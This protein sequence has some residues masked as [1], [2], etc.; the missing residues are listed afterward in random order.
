[1]EA[2]QHIWGGRYNP[3]VPVTDGKIPDEWQTMIRHY[4]PDYV[5]YPRDLN[6]DAIK[7]LSFLHPKEFID[8]PSDILKDWFA[9]VNIHCLM[10]HAMGR[11]L[12]VDKLCVLKNEMNWKTPV[13]A[14]SFYQMNLG[15][16]D[17]YMGED[18][19][20]NDIPQVSVTDKTAHLI[21]QIIT[22][23]APFFKNILSAT[24][25]TTCLLDTGSSYQMEQFEWIVYNEE[26]YLNDLLY[27]WNRQQYLKPDDRIQQIIS[28]TGEL[29]LLIKDSYFF[30]TLGH[31]AYTS[32]FSLVS[33]S[34]PEAELKELSDAIKVKNPRFDLR[35]L[36]VNEFPFT[37]FRLN[38]ISAKYFSPVNNLI[39][40]S[41][42]FLKF[43]P[44]SF[45]SGRP[46]N[47][48]VYA[49]DTIIQRT[50]EESN[51]IKFPFETPLHHLL[52]ESKCRVN[53]QRRVTLFANDKMMGT[54]IKISSDFEIV[55]GLLNAREKYGEYISL[56]VQYVS[57][58]N[59]GQKLSALFKLLDE[60]WDNLQSFLEER[61]WVD[62]F[63]YDSLLKGSAIKTGKGVFSLQDLKKEVAGLF[64]KYKTNVAER[65]NIRAEQNLDEETVVRIIER[66]IRESF[67]LYINPNLNYL[68]K[69]SG[70][71]V[72]MKVSCNICGS[73]KWYSLAELSQE[74]NCKG[75]Y[76]KIFPDLNS[77]VYYK[78][79]DVII[80]NF[81]CD[82]TKNAKAFDGNYVVLKTLLHL[83][84]HMNFRSDSFI[85]CPPLDFTAGHRQESWS[86]DLDIVAIQNGRFI[87]GEAKANAELFY[88]KDIRQLIW[89][90]NTFK[91]DILML[92][93]E[94]GD[95]EPKIEKIKAG[96]TTKCEVIAYNCSKPWY[97]FPGLFGLPND[98]FEKD[99]NETVQA[100]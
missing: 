11:Q 81:L 65:M 95:L 89:V 30:G 72:G 25:I 92:A 5:S 49:I 73:N 62:L 58:S 17:L 42:D 96:L 93:C 88:T 69:K 4:D 61:F 2:N 6:I 40:G 37:P 80:N 44:L 82:Q 91:P 21:N 100:V 48:G 90:A 75:C 79:S 47:E 56:P 52:C 27:Y 31:L 19:W 20:L 43:Q 15:F 10:H 55:R 22:E 74:V 26:N 54:E 38:H 59:S 97:H 3:I 36:V 84:N 64:V 1:M 34:L 99:E 66:D 94:T 39:V 7:E 71:L 60:K 9:G 45:E 67:E 50:G 33:R 12:S 53:A 41:E 16:Q 28:T 70:L 46:V 32:S 13:I 85:W 86:S 18:K 76:N 14:K 87:L 98:K 29:D 51:E 68:I 63:R 78:L 57:L 35:R 8:Y 77:S 23:K 24:H 83:R